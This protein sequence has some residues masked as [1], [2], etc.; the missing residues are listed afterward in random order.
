MLTS[1]RLRAHVDFIDTDYPIDRARGAHFEPQFTGSIERNVY[2]LSSPMRRRALDVPQFR[3]V[4]QHRQTADTSTVEIVGE[5]NAAFHRGLESRY[6]ETVV[7]CYSGIPILFHILKV[8]IYI[9]INNTKIISIQ[10]N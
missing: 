5:S 9:Y 2:R 3:I 1:A 6:H 4:E 10:F 8:Y 7:E